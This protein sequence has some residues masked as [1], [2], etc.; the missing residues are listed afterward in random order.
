M[1]LNSFFMERKKL[2]RKRILGDVSSVFNKI[3]MQEITCTEGRKKV[4]K[5]IEKDVLIVLKRTDFFRKLGDL[6]EGNLPG[7]VEVERFSPELRTRIVELT[8]Q[9]MVPEAV[10]GHFNHLDPV[11]APHACM[12]LVRLAEENGLGANLN[13][14]VVTVAKS[15]PGGQQSSL[16]KEMYTPMAK[17]A[18]ARGVDF[19]P[20]TRD[21]D[22]KFFGMPKDKEEIDSLMSMLREKGR[23]M[24]ILA[25][26]S[27]QPGRHPKGKS[28]DNIFG[29]QKIENR[30][31]ISAYVAML[32]AGRDLDQQP[33]FLPIAIDKT[34]RMISSDSL[35]PTPEG[36]ISLS[37]SLSGFLGCF[38]FKR[39]H[40][41]IRVGMPL[42]QD[43]F[44]SRLGPRWRHRPQEVNDILIREIAVLLPPNARGEYSDV[45][46]K[47]V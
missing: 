8:S 33:Y 22:A 39:V 9:G 12:R 37:D 25:G 29:L 14:F 43:Y 4:K 30:D 32:R 38:G 5:R 7:I 47:P 36:L 20:I 21:K 1:G 27:V 3:G 28:G 6:V 11:V 26:G 41:T 46:E 2:I 24:I 35:M 16:L 10:V 40:I 45:K 31:I 17:Y 13:R 34:Y 19:F 44:V 18:K 42:T 15:V 23:G